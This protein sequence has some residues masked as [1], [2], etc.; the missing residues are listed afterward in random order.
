MEFL[1]EILAKLFDSFKAKNPKLA[2]VIYLL[3]AS[4]VF[5]AENGL[6]EIVG[7]DFSKVI[8]YVAIA[9]GFMTGTR[10]TKILHPELNQVKK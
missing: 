2:A 3:L 9:L 6:G 8:E 5:W 7:Y 10:T 1:N 4:V